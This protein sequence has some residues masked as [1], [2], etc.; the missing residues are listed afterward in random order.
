MDPTRPT[1]SPPPPPDPGRPRP[2]RALERVLWVIGLALIAWAAYA[3][4]DGQLYQRRAEAAL[5]QAIAA[6]EARSAPEASAP[7]ARPGTTGGAGR[8][9]GSGHPAPTSAAPLPGDDGRSGP[10]APGEGAP[11]GRLEIPRIGL[12]VVVAEGTS[13]RVLRRAAG[14][15]PETPLPGDLGAASGNAAIAGHRDRHFRPLKDLEVGDTIRYQSPAGTA[16]Y[17]VEWTRVLQPSDTWVLRPTD[18]PALTLI[19]C[20]PFYFV[21]N[22]PERFIVRAYAVEEQ[23]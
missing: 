3:W 19:T 13:S 8:A 12:S 7:P 9:D 15:L 6:G 4:I 17:R 16:Q 21:G 14:H 1:P 10:A 11:L 2:L 22:A 18:R 23:R 5:D 20:Y